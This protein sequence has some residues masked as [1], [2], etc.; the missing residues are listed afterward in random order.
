M[1]I[2]NGGKENLDDGPASLSEDKTTPTLEFSSGLV[3]FMAS[4]DLG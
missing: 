4:D 3:E 2:T 1:H